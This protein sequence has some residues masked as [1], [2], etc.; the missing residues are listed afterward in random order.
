MADK[1]DQYFMADLY[2]ELQL[3]PQVEKRHWHAVVPGLVLVGIAAFAALWLSEHYG[4]PPILLGLLLGFALNFASADTRLLPGL[5][6][7]SQTLLRL[8]IVFLGLKVTWS[9]IAAL[10]LMPFLGLVAMMAA[11]IGVGLLTARLARL[12]LHLGLLAGGAT[13]ICGIS[14]A[15]ALWGIIGS[16]RVSQEGFAIT[17][18]GVTLA[19][20]TALA[21]Y[22]VLATSLGLT[23]AQAGFLVGASIHDVAQAIGGGFAISEGAGE[24][25]TVVKLSRVALLVPLLLLVAFFLGRSAAGEGRTFSIRQGVPWFIAGF[26]AVVIVNSLVALPPQLGEWGGSLA[27]FFLL[28]AVIAAAIKADL[29][30]I[31]GYGWRAFLP[32]VACTLAAFSIALVMAQVL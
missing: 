9:E 14:A 24:V 21:T 15:L 20:A 19:S 3:A 16:K 13:A 22:P 17:V 11:V 25:A 32:V 8:G 4:A 2:G 29:S 31:F 7:A 10:G 5:D 26:I 28:L 1:P 12:D 18:L 23:D 6:L 27:S 30:Q